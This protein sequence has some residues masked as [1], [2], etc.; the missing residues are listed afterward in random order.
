M[1]SELFGH[2]KGAFTGAI[3]NKRGLME[4]AKG[5]TLFLDEIGELPLGMQVKLFESSC[6]NGRFVPL[7]LTTRYP[8]TCGSSQQL[9]AT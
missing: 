5:G 1:E 7:G 4:I 3:E 9:I 8:Q 6:K 2:A